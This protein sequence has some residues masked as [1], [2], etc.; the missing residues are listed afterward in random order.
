MGSSDAMNDLPQRREV[1]VAERSGW[2]I[3]VFQEGDCFQAECISPEGNILRTCSDSRLS[4]TY[5]KACSLVDDF[6][7]KAQTQAAGKR[8][9]AVVKPLMLMLLY[10]TGDD[11][12]YN[13]R[14]LGRDSYINYDFGTLD[15]LESEKLLVQPQKGTRRRTYVSLTKEGIRTARDLLRSINFPGVDELLDDLEE[16]DKLLDDSE[17]DDDFS[18]DLEENEES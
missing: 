10:L 7:S 16:N 14:F 13:D 18:D 1:R 5:S 15:Q 6:I 9:N 11:N 17:E 8:R 12:Y 4:A 3:R 2:T